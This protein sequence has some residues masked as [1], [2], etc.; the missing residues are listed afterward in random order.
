MVTAF[1]MVRTGRRTIRIATD[2]VK[3]HPGVILPSGIEALCPGEDYEE[4]CYIADRHRWSFIRL[5]RYPL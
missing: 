4:V 3:H 5:H 1:R 2:T